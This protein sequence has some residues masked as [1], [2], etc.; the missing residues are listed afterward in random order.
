MVTDTLRGL[1]AGGRSQR[2]RGPEDSL[3]VTGDTFYVDTTAAVGDEMIQHVFTIMA[4]DTAA[5]RSAHSPPVGEYDRLLE[6]AK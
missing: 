6:N 4:V 2:Q 1:N 5:N 3:G